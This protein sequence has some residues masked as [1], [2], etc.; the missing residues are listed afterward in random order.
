MA[1]C[2]ESRGWDVVDA[3]TGEVNVPPEQRDIF[4][5]DLEGC[6]ADVYGTVEAVPLDDDDYVR[7]YELEIEA[8]TCLVDLGYTINP[9]SQQAFIDSYKGPEP[10]SAH[11]ELGALSEE[12]W[13]EANEK[14]PQAALTFQPSD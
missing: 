12:D 1:E 11:G 8:A 5:S 14:C 13:L 9:P 3:E 6:T 2:L 7:L 10:Y 4:A